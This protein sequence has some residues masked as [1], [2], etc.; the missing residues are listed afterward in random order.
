V[1]AKQFS[2]WKA[3]FPG[4]DLSFLSH[5]FAVM[6]RHLLGSAE[7]RGCTVHLRAW[8][9]SFKMCQPGPEHRDGEGV[10]SDVAGA[11]SLTPPAHAT[12]N[13]LP[14]WL[15]HVAKVTDATVGCIA[16]MQC[17]GARIACAAAARS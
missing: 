5:H 17:Q 13:R 4:R 15:Q 3:S 2:A 14:H 12:P 9:G 11:A 6:A 16:S 7:W 8:L 1:V 10:Q